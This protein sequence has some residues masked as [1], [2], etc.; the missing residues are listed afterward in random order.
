MDNNKWTVA[1]YLAYRYIISPKEWHHD[2]LIHDEHGST[3]ALIL[4]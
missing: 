4:A 1:M 3:V 2:P